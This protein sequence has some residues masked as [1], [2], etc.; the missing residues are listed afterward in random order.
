[1]TNE[2]DE[3]GQA[4]QAD[5]CGREPELA[6]HRATVLPSQLLPGLVVLPGNLL[7]GIAYMIAA[8][9]VA[10]TRRSFC[11]K[12]RRRTSSEA[13]CPRSQRRAWPREVVDMRMGRACPV[14]AFV[15]LAAACA[16]NV[17]PPQTSGPVQV[18]LRVEGLPAGTTVSFYEDTPAPGGGFI[19][20][21]TLGIT[22]DRIQ[23]SADPDHFI[24]TDLITLGAAEM[25]TAADQ[26]FQPVPR[27]GGTLTF[28]FHREFMLTVGKWSRGPADTSTF[29]QVMGDVTPGS[30]WVR[31]GST[32]ELRASPAPG[33]RF[34]H[35]GVF[36]QGEPGNEERDSG[37]SPTLKVTMTKP[38]NVI[39]GFEAAR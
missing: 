5:V 29:G 35:W 28:A 16:S 1:M 2:Q 31:E 13:K 23:V 22:G 11:A 27:S 34:V 39:A 38:L 8:V 25:W 12:R 10:F 6:E 3:W 30:Q 9:L 19:H 18:G 36:D 32:I 37:T 26:R 14:M 20:L 7:S 4:R 21:R 24:G 15:F 33:W 17:E